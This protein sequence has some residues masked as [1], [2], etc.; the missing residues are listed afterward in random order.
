[1]WNKT[2]EKFPTITIYYIEEIK[3][4]KNMCYY[5]LYTD[6]FL[7]LWKHTLSVSF[8]KLKQ[9]LGMYRDSWYVCLFSEV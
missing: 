3:I 8:S 6:Y 1:M 4:N 9:V 7:N 2:H 5:A